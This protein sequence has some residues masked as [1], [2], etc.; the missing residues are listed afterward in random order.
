MSDSVRMRWWLVASGF[1][2]ACGGDAAPPSSETPVTTVPTQPSVAGQPGQAGQTSAPS[3]NAGGAGSGSTTTAAASGA[4]GAGQGAPATS[5]GGT[6][7]PPTAA[8]G[9]GG[10]AAAG[11]PATAPND[12][13]SNPGVG[14]EQS[15]ATGYGAMASGGGSSPARAVGSLAEMQAAV[16]EYSG[17]GGLVLDYTGQFDFKTIPDPCT[18]HTRDGQKLEIKDKS[19]ISI[20]GRDGSAA[21]FGI[22]IKSASENI[23]IRN[24]TLG[25]LPGAGDSDMISL[26]GMSGGIP[27]N[28][29]IDHNELFSSLAECEGAGDTA[30]DGMIDIKKGVDNVTISYNHLHDHHKATLNG[31]SDDDSQTRHI[32]YHHNVFESIGSRTPLQRHGFSHI[33]NNLFSKIL[34]SGINVRMGGY[35][36]VEANFF[37]DVKNP[38]TSR[39]SEA[40]GFWELRDNNLAGAADVAA[41]NRFGITWDDGDDGTL[42]ALDWTTSEKFP[43][44]LGYSYEPASWACVRDGLRAVAGAGKKLATLTCNGESEL[45]L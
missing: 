30:F 29:W 12:P 37:Q 21:N 28:I 7:A 22:H 45:N 6:Q 39:D 40:V 16:D 18:Q 15:K 35:A 20:I 44:D 13:T 32:T 42:N 41:G 26:E 2:A 31:Y 27:K 19:N 11:Q 1:L 3:G 8:A 33:V 5:V 24:M 17:S 36:L 23:V 34:V 10:A 38:V 14:S 43:M 9:A 25:L 4:G